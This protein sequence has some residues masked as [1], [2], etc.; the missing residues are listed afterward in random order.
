MRLPRPRG[1][2]RT[3]PESVVGVQPAAVAYDRLIPQYNW[4]AHVDKTA[5]SGDDA[6]LPFSSTFAAA[7][8]GI[9]VAI[10]VIAALFPLAVM[11]ETPEGADPLAFVAT[12]VST[13]IGPSLGIGSVIAIVCLCA[14]TVGRPKLLVWYTILAIAYYVLACAALHVLHPENKP[15]A[16]PMSTYTL[17]SSATL[18][19]TTFFVM[20]AGFLAVG[21]RLHIAVPSWW[22]FVILSGFVIPAVGIYLA[23]V[24]PMDEKFP[25][26]SMSGRLHGIG[27][28]MTFG[29]LTFMPLVATGILGRRRLGSTTFKLSVAIAAIAAMTSVLLLAFVASGYGGLLQRVFFVAL[30]AWMAI[31]VLSVNPYHEKSVADNATANAA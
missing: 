19:Q 18:M 27:G 26:V 17:T 6:A 25:P 9:L 10:L 4:R 22:S 20:S 14:A 29:L 5:T 30:F 21:L 1:S 11:T 16:W 28:F 31:V 2:A 13:D 8:K 7:T 23:G 12:R 3:V 15:I 24:Y